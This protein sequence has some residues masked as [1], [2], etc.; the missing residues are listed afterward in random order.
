MTTDFE[1]LPVSLQQA[2]A[3]GDV[4][5]EEIEQLVVDN[6]GAEICPKCGRRP[7]TQRSTGLCE[8]CHYLALAQV[9]RDRQ[10][11]RAAKQE[12]YRE[13]E[14]GKRIVVCEVCKTPYAPRLE[15]Q[16]RKSDRQICPKC[17]NREES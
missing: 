14:R 4:T 8:A 15:S 5:L 12:Y 3:R 2:I 1:R 11:T 9:W 10:D 7:V 13:R 17:R 6:R 16:G